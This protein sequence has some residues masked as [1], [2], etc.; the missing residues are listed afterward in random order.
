MGMSIKRKQR[1]IKEW[2]GVPGRKDSQVFSGGLG[3]H[4]LPLVDGVDV[5]IYL[6]GLDSDIAGQHGSNQKFAVEITVAQDKDLEPDLR[7]FGDE[8]EAVLY[9]RKYV[10]FL[11]KVLNNS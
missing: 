8:E 11:M 2:G 4:P 1:R 7:T 10:D 3:A 9:A 6:T 5:D